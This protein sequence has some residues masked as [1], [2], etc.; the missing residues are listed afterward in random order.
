MA[1]F[2][3]RASPVDD[4]YE[5]ASSISNLSEELLQLMFK[6]HDAIML[7]IE[8]V[9][10]RIMDANLAAEKFYGYSLAQLKNMAI[11][12]INVLPSEQVEAERI[13]AAHEER[14]YFVFPHKKA[15]GEI[16]TVEVHSSPIVLK[17]QRIL[18]SIIHDITERRQAADALISTAA[19]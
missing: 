11:S 19:E 6:K 12:D 1:I 10:G 9:S 4:T 7:L 18:F 8:P 15:S 13:H 17:G 3:E 5:K 14:N 16:C 2:I